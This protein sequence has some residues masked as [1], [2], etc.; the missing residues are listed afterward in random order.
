[1]QPGQRFKRR[2]VRIATTTIACALL[3]YTAA[4]VI[5]LPRA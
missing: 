5:P 3:I 1:M 2:N 4:S